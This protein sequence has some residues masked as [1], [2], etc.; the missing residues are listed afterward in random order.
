MKICGRWSEQ[1]SGG[2]SEARTRSWQGTGPCLSARIEA[3]NRQKFKLIVHK[4]YWNATHLNNFK[5]IF[6]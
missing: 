2:R 3:F 5:N 6:R 4:F 1:G